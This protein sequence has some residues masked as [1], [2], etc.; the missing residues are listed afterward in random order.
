MVESELPVAMPNRQFRRMPLRGCHRF[1]Q[2]Y[3]TSACMD[4]FPLILMKAPTESST[5]TSMPEVKICPSECQPEC[6]SSCL[7][8]KHLPSI[9]PCIL[10][11]DMCRCLP[12]YVQCSENNCCVVYRA[13]AA[14]YRYSQQ[15]S[16]SDDKKTNATTQTSR[17]GNQNDS[18]EEEGGN[19]KHTAGMGKYVKTLKSMG[20]SK[21][22]EGEDNTDDE[23]AKKSSKSSAIPAKDQKSH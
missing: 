19:T 8:K 14:R 10:T 15:Y 16:L 7:E 9:V 23:K 5:T 21:K 18:S 3:C 4:R 12:G 22:S 20:A 6:L 1:C 17:K 11:D 2:P 13:M